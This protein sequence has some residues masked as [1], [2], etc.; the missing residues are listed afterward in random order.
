MKVFSSL[1]VMLVLAICSAPALAA[2]LTDQPEYDMSTTLDVSDGFAVVVADADP[3]RMQVAPGA[4]DAEYLTN[5]TETIIA[6]LGA[7]AE[8]M[9]FGGA[10]AAVADFNPA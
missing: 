2:V 5:H 10:A 6:S 7:D 8:L 4:A 3:V 1:I 9:P